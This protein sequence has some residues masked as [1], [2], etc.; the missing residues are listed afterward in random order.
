V[1]PA[2]APDGAPAFS[3]AK[4][5]ALLHGGDNK[6]P[7]DTPAPAAAAAGPSSSGTVLGGGGGGGGG[8][9]GLS[10]FPP[11]QSHRDQSSHNQAQYPQN[12]HSMAPSPAMAFHGGGASSFQMQEQPSFPNG[13]SMQPPQQQQQQQFPSSSSFSMQNPLQNIQLQQQQFMQMQQ[14]QQ[15]MFQQQ[16]QQMQQQQ[17]SQQQ[18]SGIY[19]NPNFSSSSYFPPSSA[20]PNQPSRRALSSAPSSSD[21]LQVHTRPE[22]QSINKNR[23]SSA[24]LHQPFIF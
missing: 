2:A 17:Q 21:A 14:Q 13:F 12:Q 5:L 7:T 20:D 9:S 16:M 18:P 1:L 11:L 6:A 22:N 4:L 3:A 23:K 24:D 15:L 10:V 19:Q 8:S